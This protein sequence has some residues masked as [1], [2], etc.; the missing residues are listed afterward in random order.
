MLTI[1]LLISLEMEDKFLLFLFNFI[2]P[3]EQ[4]LL[5][6]TDSKYFFSIKFE[7]TDILIFNLYTHLHFQVAL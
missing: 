2:Y 6:P 4:I 7:Q 5:F 1:F 3:W